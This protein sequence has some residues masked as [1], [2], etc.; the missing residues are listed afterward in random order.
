[1]NIIL[2][3]P[4]GAGK[5][6][7][8]DKISKE[9]NFFK[10]STGDLL[11]DEINKKTELGMKIKSSILKGHLVSDSIIN[12]L[13]EVI[14]SNKKYY[15]RLIFDGMPRTLIQAKELENS[16]SKFN[17]KLYCVFSLNV[18]KETIV[19]RIM[20]RQICSKCGLTFNEYFNV[21][22]TTK[23]ECGSQYLEKRSDDNKSTV[24][25]RY[26]TYLKQTKSIINFYKDR[27][28]LYEI[29]GEGDILSIYKEICGI[30]TTLK[31]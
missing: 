1:M 31:G 21:L 16:L 28:F 8:A 7:Q 20:G 19:K 2:F 17:Q 27:N 23:H 26:E 24:E 4:P 30:I 14:L 12:N 5:G 11:R 13:I 6:T 15:N 9:Y 22:D 18:N 10:V 25:A 3:G 29:N